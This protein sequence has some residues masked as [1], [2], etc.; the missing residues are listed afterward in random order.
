MSRFFFNVS[1]LLELSITILAANCSLK[2]PIY[3]CHSL[4]I[5]I[6]CLALLRNRQ[7]NTNNFVSQILGIDQIQLKNL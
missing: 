6:A 1:R 5:V 4:T 7:K 3:Y 2:V